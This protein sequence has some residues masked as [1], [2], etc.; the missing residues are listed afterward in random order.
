MVKKVVKPAQKILNLQGRHHTIGISE[1]T[2]QL[3][4][5]FFQT[6]SDLHLLK[7]PACFKSY[8]KLNVNLT[9]NTKNFGMHYPSQPHENQCFHDIYFYSSTLHNYA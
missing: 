8:A 2:I 9:V 5:I 1:N 4:S 3:H 6:Y 7:K